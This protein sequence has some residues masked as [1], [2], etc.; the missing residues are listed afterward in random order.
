VESKNISYPLSKDFLLKW[1]PSNP[2]FV[3]AV[4]MA[5]DHSSPAEKVFLLYL[6]P[7]SILLI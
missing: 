3:M 1:D 2:L 5:V 7:Y 6:I 4:E